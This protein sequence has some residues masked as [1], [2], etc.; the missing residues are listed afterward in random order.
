MGRWGSRWE[1]VGPET[2]S[3]LPSNFLLACE[4][5]TEGASES[6]LGSPGEAGDCFC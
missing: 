6:T 4:V 2:S 5:I 3:H 1:R